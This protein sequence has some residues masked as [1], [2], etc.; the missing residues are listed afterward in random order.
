[1]AGLRFAFL[2]GMALGCGRH[3]AASAPCTSEQ[4]MLVVTAMD[5]EMQPL[6]AKMAARQELDGLV[7]GE[8]ADRPVLLG[9]VGVG[10]IASSRTT[11]AVLERFHVAGVV[12]VGIA[13]GLDR[14]LRIGDVT[15]PAR[16][17]RYD[18]EPRWF[19]ADPLLL[20][21]GQRAAAAKLRGCDDP[22]VCTPAPRVNLGGAGATGARFVS[23]PAVGE[24]IQRR[25]GAVVTEMETASVAEVARRHGVPFVAV[26]AISDLVW[27]GRSKDLVDR[28]DELAE[29]NAAAVAIALLR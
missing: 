16:W 26:R 6:L 13:G 14:A 7:C 24:D 9:V 21:A 12:M 20:A 18:R 4:T 27:T 17:S 23:D 29:N 3:E 5:D 10:P 1:M 25:L 28:Y 8:L 22:T 15:I 2:A 19:D 11:E